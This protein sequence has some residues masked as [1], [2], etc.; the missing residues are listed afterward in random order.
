MGS[1]SFAGYDMR[2]RRD[3]EAV[4][5]IITMHIRSNGFEREYQVG[6][7]L[8]W[9][10][11]GGLD[12][13]QRMFCS[14]VSDYEDKLAD[15]AYKAWRE[16]EKDYEPHLEEVDEDEDEDEIIDQDS[17]YVY[18]YDKYSHS[19]GP[20]IRQRVVNEVVEWNA[21]YES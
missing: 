4:D 2:V 1:N 6:R 15:L 10:I 16:A 14:Q 11:D 7:I 20:R 3:G 8:Y 21:S 17:E 5:T 19:K 18:Y 12:E 13:I 9:V